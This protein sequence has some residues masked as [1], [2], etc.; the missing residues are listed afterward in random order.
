MQVRI[1]EIYHKQLNAHGYV[2]PEKIKNIVLGILT[3]SVFR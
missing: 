1:D 2:L 3:R